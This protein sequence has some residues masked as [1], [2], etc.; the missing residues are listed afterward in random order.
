MTPKLLGLDVGTSR[1]KAVVFDGAGVELASGQRTVVTETPHPGWAEQ[2]MDAVW[3][4]AADVI[5]H[6]LGSLPAGPGSI[7]AIGVTGQGDGAWMI[8]G[9]GRP[10]GKAPLWSDGRAAP[11]IERWDREGVL[12]DAFEPNGTIL[13]PG[14][15]APLLVWLREHEP[16]R[17]ERMRSVFCAKDWVRFRLTDEVATDTTDASIPF[18]RLATGAYDADQ[19]RRLGLL[20]LQ[21]RLPAVLAP[22]ATAGVVTAAAAVATGLRPG[23]PVVAGMLDGVACGIG[24]GAVAPGQAMTIL[25]TTALVGL[26]LD[27]PVFTPAGIGATVCHALAGRWLRILGAMAGTPNLDWYLATI[28]GTYAQ[29]ATTH[30]TSVYELLDAAIAR[31]PPGAHGV[32]YHPFLLGERAPF[33]EPAATG[34][35]FGLSATTTRDD[36]TRAIYEGISFAVRHC[37][38]S[39]TGQVDEVRLAGGGA[40]SRVWAQLLADVTRVPMVVPVGSHFGARGAAIAAGLGTGVYPSYEEAVRRAVR[41]ERRHEPDMNVRQRYAERFARYLELIESQRAFWVRG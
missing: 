13:W 29:E 37:L 23:T 17:I 1:I 25:G 36:V 24:V 19:L 22:H 32:L 33:L 38:E 27:K 34:A 41:V 26:V 10:V 16:D 39:I 2:D 28:G 12:Q 18:L 21:D 5:R 30:D 8:D 3:A 35:V 20:D 6:A 31:S 40:G 9:A 7:E 4:A 15:Q 14:A 11:I